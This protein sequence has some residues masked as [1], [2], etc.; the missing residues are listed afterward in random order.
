MGKRSLTI[1]NIP[2]I[3]KYI[4]CTSA[5]TY[6]INMKIKELGLKF[7]L[8]PMKSEAYMYNLTPDINI[9]KNIDNWHYDYMPFVFVYMIK[10]GNTSEGNLILKLNGEKKKINLEEGEGIFMQGSQIEHMAERCRDGERVTLVLSFIPDDITIKDN[11]YV[12]NDMNPY[13]PNESLH[14][15]YLEY[16]NRRVIQLLK[17]KKQIARALRNEWNDIQRS[18]IGNNSKI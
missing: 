2:E 16:K 5:I 1:R 11:T 17:Y 18:F 9:Q 14:K 13:H 12:T 15:Q 3:D 10:K 8:H 6:N 7:K 4:R